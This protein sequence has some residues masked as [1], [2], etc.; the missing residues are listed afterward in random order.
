MSVL[1]RIGNPRQ[2]PGDLADEV[3]STLCGSKGG[4]KR[5][6]RQL[7]SEKYDGHNR[8]GYKELREGS[9]RFEMDQERQQA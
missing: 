7:W 9:D 1:Q 5:P 8:N 3:H 6:D 2:R 4:S